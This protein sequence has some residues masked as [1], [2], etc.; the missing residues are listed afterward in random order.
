MNDAKNAIETSN[1]GYVWRF[2]YG[3]NI[4][5]ETLQT[6]KNLNP[7]RYL[8]GTIQGFELYF[9]KGFQYVEP[10]WAAVRP[11]SP[12]QYLHGSAFLIPREEAR[13]LDRQEGGYD[14]LP[15]KFE[16]Y[17]GEIVEN[18]CL[19][20]PKKRDKVEKDSTEAVEEGI[21]S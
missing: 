14:V 19:Y 4:G 21:P 17:D 12:S 11:S 7:S 15:C 1:D 2:G 9:M 3:S 8:T 6:K 13:G 16:S 18:V 10:G 5:L 20:V